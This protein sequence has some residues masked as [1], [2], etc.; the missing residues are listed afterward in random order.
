MVAPGCVTIFRCEVVSLSLK[1]QA[2]GRRRNGELLEALAAAFRVWASTRTRTGSGPPHQAQDEQ[3]H[4]RLDRRNDEAV[5]NPNPGV[6]EFSVRPI[7][8]VLGTG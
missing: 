5:Y 3:Q 2:L 4:D 1:G 6:D 8:G 7:S